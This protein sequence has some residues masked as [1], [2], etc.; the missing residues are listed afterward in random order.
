[1]R[2]AMVPALL[3]AGCLLLSCAH[4]EAGAGK[5]AV[6]PGL[7]E[8]TILLNK[9]VTVVR[10]S[11]GDSFKFK[12]GRFKGSGVRLMGYNSLEA[13]GPV[14]RWGGWT[15]QELYAIS[16]ATKDIA[17]ATQWNCITDGS[18]D[19]YNRVL[20]DCP[21]ARQELL[22]VG[23]GHVYAFDQ[24][25]DPTDL[26]VQRQ[27]REQGLGIWAKGTPEHIITSVHSAAEGRGRNRLVSTRTGKTW[28]RPHQEHY[29][30]C[31]EIC[32]GPVASGSCMVYVPYKM[33][34]SDKPDCL[35]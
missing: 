8:A 18:K 29:E 6:E 3:L 9:K 24:D 10:W 11:D 13:Y 26:A 34:Y 35:R 5:N 19:S 12:S 14:H 1:M 21:D 25:A 16:S 28:L 20:V 7:G 22:R 27:A 4:N 15:A 2:L 30:V 33:R 17:S 32:E 31:Q 23:H